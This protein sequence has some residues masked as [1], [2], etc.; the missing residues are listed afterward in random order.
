MRDRGERLRIHVLGLVTIAPDVTPDL[1]CAVIES[2]TVLGALHTSPEVRAVL[3][4]L[5]G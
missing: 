4:E 1:A 2:I 3:A 5:T